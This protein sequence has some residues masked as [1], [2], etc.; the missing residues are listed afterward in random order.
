MKR[1]N[2]YFIVITFCI[3][4]IFSVNLVV[5]FSIQTFLYCLFSLCIVILPCIVYVF[6]LEI[7][8][9]KLFNPYKKLFYVFKFENKIYES[10]KIKKWKDKIPVMKSVKTG[11]DKTRIDYPKNPEYLWTFLTENCKA[12][13]GHAIS[14]VWSIISVIIAMLVLPKYMILS[15]WLPV[16]LIS[17]ILHYIPIIVQR[18]MRPRLLKLYNLSITKENNIKE[19]KIYE[20]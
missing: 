3:L 1:N 14:I 20:K 9:T 19:A 18:Y 11:F 10:I 15:A 12:E 6:I 2:L 5:K 7:L 4:I 8:S 17:V 13:T 16:A